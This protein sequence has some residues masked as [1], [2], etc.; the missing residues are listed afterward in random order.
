METQKTEGAA[1]Y[2]M[3]IDL[4]RCDG[5]GAC[6]VACAV[7]NNVPPGPERATERTGVSWLR[8]QRIS[9]PGEARAAFVPLMCQQCGARTPCASVCPQNAVEVDPG[10][11]IVAQVA[12]RCLGCRYCMAACPYH[13]R[14][15]NWWDP[16]WPG[17]LVETL[18][19]DVSTRTRGVVEKCSFCSHRLQQ[20]RDA[21]AASDADPKQPAEYQPACVQAC[22]ASAIRFGD[23]DDPAGEAARLARAP[24]SFRLLERLGTGAKVYYHTQRDWVRRLADGP[25]AA[26]DGRAHG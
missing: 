13:A 21:Q 6:A 15:F 7:E 22:P 16:D 23:L 26:A 12:V 14:S 4:D 25:A 5:C 1:R 8:V 9:A 20:A 10:S 19:P 17:R 3:V 11:G 2:G 18:N 24:G